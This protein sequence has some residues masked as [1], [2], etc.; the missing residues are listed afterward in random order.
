MA[1]L[2]NKAKNNESKPRQ[3]SLPLMEA[4]AKKA[5]VKS[6]MEKDFTPAEIAKI[7]AE[8]EKKKAAAEAES[9][10]AAREV[11]EEERE[12][13]EAEERA[14]REMIIRNKKIARELE[15]DN[16][17]K[18]ILFPSYSRNKSSEEIEWYKMGD[19]SALYYVHRMSM[20]MGRKAKLIKDTDRFAKMKYI[21]CVRDID[22]F[23]FEA[24]QLPE[25]VKQYFTP[26]DFCIL[27]MKEPLTADEIGV[28]R[29]T[30]AVRRDMM[31]NVLK[32][33]QADAAVFQAIT[34]LNEQLLPRI[35]RLEYGYAVTI[36]QEL[37]RRYFNVVETYYRFASGYIETSV[38]KQEMLNAI[39]SLLAGT[40]ML[41]DNAGWGFDVAS[42]IGEN[43]ANLKR[44]VLEM[45]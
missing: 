13:V 29:R 15:K 33:R 6:K 40:L 8:R 41:G 1:K 39:E 4:V 45:K 28:L 32:P 9:D 7:N 42:A 44:L 18:I 11:L 35:N 36:G 2:E 37:T 34:M 27:E 21:A 10:A 19:F 43:I 38:A 26:D 17:S 22:K 5:P 30:D 16:N 31:H 25:F 24:M 3:M 14:Y 12:R 23:V 20:R